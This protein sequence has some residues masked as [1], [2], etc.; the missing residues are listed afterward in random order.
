MA[1]SLTA[2]GL[3]ACGLVAR[4]LVARGLA[5]FG[6]A[7]LGLAAGGCA[8]GPAAPAASVTAGAARPAHWQPFRHVPG[9]VDLAP[10]RA[11]GA[12][13]VA[14]AGHLFL[15]A[16]PGR[17][18]AF[19]R[20]AGGYATAT[21][22]EPYIALATG[23]PV[24]AASC[25]FGADST[26]A[27]E[28]A[29]AP[30][31]ISIDRRGQAHRFASLPGTRPNGIVFDGVGRFGHRLLVTASAAGG[32]A[33]FAIDCA[34]QV[35]T[36]TSHAP[37]AEGGIAVAPPSFGAF[38]GD[39]I[40]PDEIT[41]RIWAIGPDGQARLVARSHLPSGGD[42]GSESAGFVPAGFGPDWAA[43]VADR[44]VPGNRHPGTDSILRL[45]GAELTAAGAGPGALVVASEGG[46]QT[47]A[48]AC[49]ATCTVRHIADGPAPS[50]VEGH[51]VFAP[52]ATSTAP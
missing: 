19:A 35:T 6:L 9:V 13:T 8:T 4:G 31:V 50:H 39:L 24:T 45:P 12:L 14:A 49:A 37:R 36:I 5:V 30:G 10:P 28:P 3:A 29:T 51:I 32:A 40:T 41:G 2:R 11:G 44:R 27:L 17:L 22:P 42:I 46:A 21:G 1:R 15:L 25:P 18:V 33:V 26:Y 34:G 52:S 20:G 47:V 48:I 43:Y 7:V 23:A 38:G 16:A